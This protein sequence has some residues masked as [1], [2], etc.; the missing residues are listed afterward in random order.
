M[1]STVTTPPPV[2][3]AKDAREKLSLMERLKEG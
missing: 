2:M 1:A 3:V